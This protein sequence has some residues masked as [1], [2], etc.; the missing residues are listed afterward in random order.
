MVWYQEGMA[1]LGVFPLED[2]QHV[3]H[4][5]LHYTEANAIFYLGVLQDIRGMMSSCSLAVS[6][7]DEGI[8]F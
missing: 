4:F 7:G 1:T 8:A 2:V 3:V 5:I 6:G